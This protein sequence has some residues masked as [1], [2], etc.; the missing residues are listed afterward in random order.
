MQGASVAN[1]SSRHRMYP[2]D[3]ETDFT[4]GLVSSLTLNPKP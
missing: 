1:S 2:N 3:L 4:L